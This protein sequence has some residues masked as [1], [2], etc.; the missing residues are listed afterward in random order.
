[1][2]AWVTLTTGRDTAMWS[3]LG[4]QGRR[5]GGTA[6]AVT[7]GRAYLANPDLVRRWTYGAA[8]NVARTEFLYT[9]GALGYT[10]Y[11]SMS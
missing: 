3:I 10:D 7:I 6:D 2:P 9:V 11:P 8:L 1:M 5:L 4:D